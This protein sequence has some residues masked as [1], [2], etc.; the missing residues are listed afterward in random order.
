MSS[1]ALTQRIALLAALLFTGCS[2]TAPPPQTPGPPAVENLTG[3]GPYMF[4]CDAAGGKPDGRSVSIPSDTSRVTGLL[5]F[6]TT[7]RDIMYESSAAVELI[8]PATRTA[9]A[10]QLLVRSDERNTVYIAFGT[11]SAKTVGNGLASVA[12]AS[13]SIGWSLSAEGGAS[14]KNVFASMPFSSEPIPFAL[15]ID[16]SGTVNASFGGVDSP[17]PLSF[18]GATRLAIGCSTA[19]VRFSNVTVETAGAGGR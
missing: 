13:E 15:T 4:D 3:P 14:S 9:A 8:A 18:S 19:S 17:Q 6:V 10:L 2:T 12:S 11:V 5:Q 7:R 1:P 16:R